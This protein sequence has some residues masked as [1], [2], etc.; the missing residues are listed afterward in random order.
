MSASAG[1]LRKFRLKTVTKGAYP[2]CGT[3]LTWH[4]SQRNNRKEL[5]T[6][7]AFQRLWRS[8]STV[9]VAMSLM[10]SQST[11][12][13]RTA[14][15]DMRCVDDGPTESGWFLSLGCLRRTLGYRSDLRDLDMKWIKNGHCNQYF[16]L[17]L[18]PFLIFLDMSPC[19][20]LRF[21]FHRIQ[22]IELLSLCKIWSDVKSH[23]CVA[24]AL[25]KPLSLRRILGKNCWRPAQW[26][27]QFDG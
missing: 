20:K 3:W 2:T 21:R 24:M 10:T 4:K 13:G 15:H 17:F 14:R 12:W 8:F 19:Q 23:T 27:A 6:F 16:W 18:R 9:F 26:P 5:H 11:T 1:S 25:A 22:S 7:Q